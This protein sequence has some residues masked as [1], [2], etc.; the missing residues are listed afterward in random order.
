MDVTDVAFSGGGSAKHPA[1]LRRA[2]G[3]AGRVTTWVLLVVTVL[4]TTLLLGWTVLGLALLGSG[5]SHDAQPVPAILAALLAVSAASAW[6][7]ARYTASW[8]SIGTTIAAIVTVVLLVGGTW[9]LSAPSQ[10]LYVA[11]NITW[12][13]TD[14]G[15][16]RKYPQRALHNAPA[17][18]EFGQNLSPH[19][20]RSIQYRQGGRL[21][22]TSVEEF[23]SSTR[24]AAF[25][26]IKDG[27][28]LHESYAN[29][30]TRDSMIS[31][32]SIAKSF[33]SAL[34]GV[35]IDE[36][37]IGSVDDAM[38]SYLPELRGKG[39]D[40]VTLRHLLTMSAGIGY[41]HE[42]EQSWV[43]GPLPST[44]MRAPPT[45]PTSGASHSRSGQ[46]LTHRGQSSSTTTSYRC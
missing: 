24:T 27:S 1:P 43:F 29:G 9:A 30:Y 45:S 4:V 16:H 41:R 36:G 46:A 6:L 3:A 38:V 13:G 8:R 11:R 25:I 2:L 21:K 44:T 37:Y 22:Q 18:F 12:D 23:L 5:P 28:I 10:A 7:T 39:L 26:V 14:I 33:T 32:F 17:A 20:F 42:D 15:D 40:G 35:A 19:L 31:S 34:I